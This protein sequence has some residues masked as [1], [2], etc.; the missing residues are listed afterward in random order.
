MNI[1]RERN[2]VNKKKYTHSQNSNEFVQSEQQ[3]DDQGDQEGKNPLSHLLLSFGYIV[4]DVVFVTH[5]FLLPLILIFDFEG[6]H[7]DFFQR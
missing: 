2:T 4:R 6:L 7:P 5:R 3:T 1:N